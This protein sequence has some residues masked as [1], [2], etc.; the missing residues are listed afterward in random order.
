MAKTRKE[1]RALRVRQKMQS[2]HNIRQLHEL[3]D[4]AEVIEEGIIQRLARQ[5]TKEK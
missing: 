2:R 4:Q 3:L 5:T 1:K